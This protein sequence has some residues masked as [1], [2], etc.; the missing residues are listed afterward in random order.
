MCATIKAAALHTLPQTKL[1]A[2]E[3]GLTVQ[4]VKN[5]L[6]DFR[7]AFGVQGIAAVSF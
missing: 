1:D 5:K 6:V 4:R 3:Y 2:A 7:R